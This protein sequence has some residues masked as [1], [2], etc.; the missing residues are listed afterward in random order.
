M[1][2][3]LIQHHTTHVAV[4]SLVQCTSMLLYTIKD[5]GLQRNGTLYD[6]MREVQLAILNWL[7]IIHLLDSLNMISG[8]GA[9]L[10]RQQFQYN[11]LTQS[12]KQTCVWQ[13]PHLLAGTGLDVMLHDAMGKMMMQINMCI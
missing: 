5:S 13:P 11:G 8:F 9:H 4:H 2:A 10:H 7:K 12:G 6:V 1:L 3:Q